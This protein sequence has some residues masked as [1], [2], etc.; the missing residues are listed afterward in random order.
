MQGAASYGYDGE[1]TSVNPE[2]R[3]GQ[4]AWPL[5]EILRRLGPRTDHRGGRR[6]PVRNFN[7]FR[8]WSSLWILNAVDRAAYVST[9]DR[10]PTH[11]RPVGHGYRA[12]AR[13]RRAD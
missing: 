5:K 8:C 2:G 12:R 4:G 13:S 3:K 7:L 11:V 1:K 10:G 9:D 6:R